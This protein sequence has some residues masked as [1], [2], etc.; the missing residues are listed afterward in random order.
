MV[1]LGGIFVVFFWMGQIWGEDRFFLLLYHCGR[2]FY[3]S[4]GFEEQVIKMY[5]IRSL[6]GVRQ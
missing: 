2:N 4:F 5:Y 1:T 6:E 3:A